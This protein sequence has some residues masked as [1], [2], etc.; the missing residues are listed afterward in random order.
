MK[1]GVSETEYPLFD[2][3]KE[4]ALDSA[5]HDAF[6]KVFLD[7]GIHAQDGHGGHDDHSV[8]HLI[9]GGLSIAALH[10]AVAV[11][12]GFVLQQD[13]AQHHLQGLDIVVG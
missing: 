3:V 10:A 9:G 2:F 1:K 4:S 13:A 11:G 5:D 6:F 7:E 8:L 12:K